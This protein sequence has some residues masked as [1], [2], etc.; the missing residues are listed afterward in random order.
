MIPAR[1][2]FMLEE[3]QFITEAL[4]KEIKSNDYS[5]I[6]IYKERRN[7]VTGVIKVKEFALKYLKE[8]KR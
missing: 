4:A 2:F 8:S 3:K 7:K 6:L 1:D 5:Y